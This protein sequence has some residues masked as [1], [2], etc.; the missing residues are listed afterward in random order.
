MLLQFK[1][2][3][4]D[5]LR[6]ELRQ[7]HLCHGNG[8]GGCVELRY[9][10]QA[11]DHV[12]EALEVLLHVIEGRIVALSLTSEIERHVQP[13]QRRAQF[14]RDVVDELTLARDELLDAGGHGI[15]VT[16]QRPEFI[17]PALHAGGG[18]RAEIAR[19]QLLRSLA[20]TEDGRGEI[21]GEQIADEAR[22]QKRRRTIAAE[23][24][25]GPMPGGGPRCSVDST[26]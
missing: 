13:G 11:P 19:R 21:A 9:G 24:P 16:H 3:T 18:T 20:Q 4:A 10:E 15:E 14:V 17:A 5:D 12:I 2:G 6:Y 23:C 26:A 7:I 1:I 25:D 22:D 8:R